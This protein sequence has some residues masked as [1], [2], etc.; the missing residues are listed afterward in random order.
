MDVFDDWVDWKE[1]HPIQP[2]KQPC[3][4]IE[5]FLPSVIVSLCNGDMMK[6]RCKHFAHV[7]AT[8]LLD[9]VNGDGGAARGR[10]DLKQSRLFKVAVF[11]KGITHGD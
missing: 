9:V 5:F 11:S 6:P 8:E 10:I 7:G 2:S 1:T 3:F 4:D